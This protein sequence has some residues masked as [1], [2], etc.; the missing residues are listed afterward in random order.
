MFLKKIV[1]CDLQFDFNKGINIIH[2]DATNYDFEVCATIFSQII[3]QKYM[4]IENYSDFPFLNHEAEYVIQKQNKDYSCSL[5]FNRHG[6]LISNDDF[7]TIKNIFDKEAIMFFSQ[8]N[9][10]LGLTRLQ[11]RQNYQNF[12]FKESDY[13]DYFGY[14]L[15]K[16]DQLF[17]SNMF[18]DNKFNPTEY[19][20]YHCDQ[21]TKIINNL[22]DINKYSNF[23]YSYY[24]KCFVCY[25]DG[26]VTT[27]D[28]QNY[29]IG[30][31]IGMVLKIYRTLLS[32]HQNNYIGDLKQ[33]SG[34][35]ISNLEFGERPSYSD[36]KWNYYNILSENFQNVE[37]IL[38]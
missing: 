16:N 1:I 34:I 28:I 22:L 4:Y 3:K 20:K 31:L 9:T 2:N 29:G 33:D 17:W 24:Y 25:K 7:T 15:F 23:Q 27:I 8:N 21:I 36:K 14:V 32:K 26:S 37:F 12:K 19:T 5:K 6:T 18:I 30:V 13:S 10:Y 35:V 38:I 11:K